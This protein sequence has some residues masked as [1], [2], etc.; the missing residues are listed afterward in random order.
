M[1]CLL[2]QLREEKEIGSW[3]FR[4]RNGEKVSAKMEHFLNDEFIEPESL[5]ENVIKGYR[6]G[7]AIVP[8]EET[9]DPKTGRKSLVCI[10]FT[11]KVE[12]SELYLAG[13]GIWAVVPQKGYQVSAN[14]LTAL[15]AAMRKTGVAM[16]ARYT[17]SASSAPK[18]MILFSNDMNKKHPEHNSLLM[19][20]LFFKQNY[21]KVEFPSFRTKNTEPSAEQYEV[22][23]KFIDSMDLMK[24][25]AGD[26][27]EQSHK[28]H[29]AFKKLLDPALQHMYR[30]IANRA[31][32]P[33]DPVL[34]VDKDL[35]D[36]LYPPSRLQERAKPHIER[37]K[38]LFPLEVAK[39]STK[40][41]LFE[42]LQ[43]HGLNAQD[44]IALMDGAGDSTDN[45]IEIGTA[46]PAEDFAELMNRGERFPTLAAQIQK[47]IMSIVFQ[48]VEMPEEK[49][50][51]ALLIYR[52]FAKDKGPFRY[53]EWIES[54]KAQLLERGKVDVWQKIIVAERYGLITAA[55]SEI[56][57][58]TDSE[59]A[60]FY[61]I[62]VDN[63]DKM[64]DEEDD[65]D[66]DDLLA[67]M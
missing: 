18:M 33:K 63:T 9:D 34:A 44:N 36:L 31:I 58:V 45:I 65:S 54:F 41:A 40:C 53:N 43:S 56:S 39:K 25:T 62:A 47:V 16:I 55:E 50:S 26:D 35:K 51:K 38:E 10:G 21:I 14:M 1:I 11:K 24:T 27:V 5:V 8:Y 12:F 6:F 20:E 29:E 32:N 52:E 17:Y 60:Q 42:K 30:A 2:P 28:S 4:S 59:A 49:V 48:S 61:Q 64:D 46:S 3:K 23:D 15:V 67:D 37:A 7:D 19:Y 13:T 22:M 57:T 66:I